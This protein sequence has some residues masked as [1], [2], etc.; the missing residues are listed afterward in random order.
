MGL[1]KGSYHVLFDV[2]APCL[3]SCQDGNCS[4]VVCS[5]L[6]LILFCNEAEIESRVAAHFPNHQV[7]IKDITLYRS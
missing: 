2:A 1:A 7:F 6:Q 4:F 5:D 3:P